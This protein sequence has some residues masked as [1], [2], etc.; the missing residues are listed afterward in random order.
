MYAGA[1][2]GAS[3]VQMV[4]TR[5]ANDAAVGYNRAFATRKA[6]DAV[7]GYN[8]AN[9][10][11]EANDEEA[12]HCRANA[13]RD[14]GLAMSRRKQRGIVAASSEQTFTQTHFCSFTKTEDDLLQ[15][16]LASSP[17]PPI[18]FFFTLTPPCPPRFA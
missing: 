9:A 1:L 10:T 7:V 14:V 18:F 17:R 11:R 12:G 3:Y 8:R 5:K 15:L 4:A 16:A 2:T 6:G 13:N